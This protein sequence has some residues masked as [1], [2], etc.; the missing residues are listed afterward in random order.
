VQCHKYSRIYLTNTYYWWL[1][2]PTITIRF[3]SKW[4]KH[5]SHSTASVWLLLHIGSLSC[6]C[7]SSNHSHMLFP[8]NHMYCWLLTFDVPLAAASRGYMTLQYNHLSGF[9]S[10]LAHKK[11]R[12]LTTQGI[13]AVTTNFGSLPLC[14]QSVVDSRSQ[15]CDV[16]ISLGHP[17]KLCLSLCQDRGI[18]ATYTE[19][20]VSLSKQTGYV[21]ESYK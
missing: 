20:C 9:N 4:N 17:A 8:A 10:F 21:C 1:L 16:D 2:R 19:A 11:D 6:A 13:P 3:D 18:S 5:Y 14:N 12:H 15:S 7:Q